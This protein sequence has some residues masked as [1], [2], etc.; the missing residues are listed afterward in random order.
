[1]VMSKIVEGK[2]SQCG[3]KLSEE[4]IDDALK[5]EIVEC[6]SCARILYMEENIEENID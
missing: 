5:K 1:V 2:C 4:M 6:P 3:F